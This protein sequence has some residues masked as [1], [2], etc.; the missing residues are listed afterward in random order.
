MVRTRGAS[1]SHIRG[2][3]E[4]RHHVTPGPDDMVMLY[5]QENIWSGQIRGINVDHSLISALLERWGWVT[6]TFHL[7]VGKMTPTLQ[8]ITMLTGLP[9]DGALVIG[10]GGAVDLDDLCLRLL[11]RVPLRISYRGDNLKL[12]WLASSFQIPL[13]EAI[14][15]QLNMYARGVEW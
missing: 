13:D 14:E 11:G 3:L 8:D 7:R 9:I 10:P 15:D 2:A 12:T 1:S 4:D 5:L 6:H